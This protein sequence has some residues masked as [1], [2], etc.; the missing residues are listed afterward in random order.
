MDAG[1]GFLQMYQSQSNLEAQGVKDIKVASVQVKEWAPKISVFVYN[2]KKGITNLDVSG[3]VQ[4]GDISGLDSVT[5]EIERMVLLDGSAIVLDLCG[6]DAIRT[7]Y[8][9]IRKNLFVGYP[10]QPIITND[11]VDHNFDPSHNGIYYELDISG[12]S[13][14]SGNVDVSSNLGVTGTLS[15]TG[16]IQGDSNANIGGDLFVDG[17]I[18]SIDGTRFVDYRKYNSDISGSI[19]GVGNTQWY[20][21]A[22]IDPGPAGEFANAVFILDD[23]TSGLRQSIIFRAGSSY[24]RGNFIDVL[25]NHFYSGPKITGIRIDTSGNDLYQGANLYIQRGHTYNPT[26]LFIRV[27][28]NKRKGTDGTN[29]GWWQL[30]STPIPNL[31]ATVAQ[32]NLDFQPSGIQ[33]GSKA[34]TLDT[35]IDAQLK[36]NDYT[37]LQNG[38][39]V[40]ISGMNIIL[41]DQL[42][43]KDTNILVKSDMPEIYHPT[44]PPKTTPDYYEIAFINQNVNPPG[45]NNPA[46]CVTAY[47][48]FTNNLGTGALTDSKQSIHFIAGIYYTASDPVS[49][50]KVLSNNFNPTDSHISE[51]VIAEDTAAQTAYL[52]LGFD[53]Q[54]STT[55]ENCEIRMYKNSNG[56]QTFTN[57]YNGGGWVLGNRANGPGTNGLLDIT[58]ISV[59]PNS[60]YSVSSLTTTI[61]IDSTVPPNAYSNLFENFLRPVDISANARVGGN[62]LVDGQLTVN[63]RTTL[64]DNLRARD[65]SCNYLQVDV[66][67]SENGG[68]IINNTGSGGPEIKFQ[69]T[70]NTY[71]GATRYNK[72]YTDDPTNDL[73]IDFGTGSGGHTMYLDGNTNS[74]TSVVAQNLNT[75]NTVVKALVQNGLSMNLSATNSGRGQLSLNNGFTSGSGVG[76]GIDIQCSGTPTPQHDWY[77]GGST[78]GTVGAAIRLKG[79]TET[80]GSFP[81]FASGE[82]RINAQQAGS[83]YQD[84]DFAIN[85][86]TTQNAL[87]VDAANN[88]VNIKIP[89]SVD[90]DVTIDGNL[91]VEEDLTFGNGATIV[92]TNSNTLTITEAT[93]AITGNLTVSGT[94]TLNDLTFDNLGNNGDIVNLPSRTF[95]NLRGV[96]GNYKT[97]TASGHQEFSFDTQNINPS[98]WIS[99]AYVGPPNLTQSKKQR[100]TGKFEFLNPMSGCHQTICA[101]VNFKFGDGLTID[102]I[103]NVRY[104]NGTRRQIKA[105]RIAYADTYDGGILQMQIGDDNP[106]NDSTDIHLKISENWDDYGWWCDLSG[107]PPADNNPVGYMVISDGTTTNIGSAFTTF[108]PNAAGVQV[109]DRSTGSN[110]GKSTL[111]YTSD[112]VFNKVYMDDD[113]D[114]SGNQILNATIPTILPIAALNTYTTVTLDYGKLA[115]ADDCGNTHSSNSTYQREAIVWRPQIGSNNNVRMF[116]NEHIVPLYNRQLT[117]SVS[118]GGFG[119]SNSVTQGNYRK[120]TPTF[121][122]GFWITAYMGAFPTSNDTN[123]SA[124]PISSK[125][126][127]LRKAWITGLYLN[128]PWIDAGSFS[129]TGNQG[130]LFGFG[131]NSYVEIQI[132]PI[133]GGYGHKR[134]Y[135]I[136]GSGVTDKDNTIFPS[137]TWNNFGN[138]GGIRITLS[139]KDWIY[140]PSGAN[141]C[142]VVRFRARVE[143]EFYVRNDYNST[144]YNYGQVDGYLLYTSDPLLN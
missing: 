17:I 9:Y 71:L 19:M 51:L 110:V 26:R 21:V 20:C 104:G 3:Q 33:G 59:Y 113:L 55:M 140:I 67:G 36:V 46:D 27:Y 85:T 66:S 24:S 89:L 126:N 48:T 56:K 90:A 77:I 6:N 76:G 131:T 136:G 32:L 47:F 63:G 139:A 101:Y 44:G 16:N 103:K 37:T 64:N 74:A 106:A 15:V 41:R 83:G 125:Y 8:E 86:V 58:H 88:T 97:L 84:I 96:A 42:N 124:T 53:N 81:T 130:G 135:R 137:A 123:P 100:A 68:I 69:R 54:S 34:T 65:I 111:M 11:E 73:H 128:T 95:I 78:T 92:N 35:L 93:T 62:L 4:V 38:Q 117:G 119:S 52:I 70:D 134:V 102:I 116:V 72:I 14:I 80:S 45:T 13:Y 39:F 18:E 109:L 114:M 122:S 142:Q 98:D 60:P 23:D 141:M 120:Y 144:N 112:I 132:G 75:G 108:W 12:N 43:I 31:N 99:I 7:Q 40:D 28:Q 57:T 127:F 61:K 25:T 107:S 22:K 129:N 105:F 91:Q 79:L 87:L 1:T 49:F 115:I 50:I 10:T 29:V 2:G 5:R 138:T 94:S 118:D 121:G 30:T 82:V 143:D 133:S